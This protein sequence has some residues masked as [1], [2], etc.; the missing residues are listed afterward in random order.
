MGINTRQKK[1]IENINND[2]NPDGV[3]I[4]LE[5]NKDK[6]TDVTESWLL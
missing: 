6:I 1:I 4:K 5:L 3:Y 2:E